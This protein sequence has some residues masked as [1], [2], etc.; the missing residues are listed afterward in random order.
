M[1]LRQLRRKYNENRIIN[2]NNLA[3][4]R[5]TK[6][7]EE[8]GIETLIRLSGNH[9]DLF[10]TDYDEH[11]WGYTLIQPDGKLTIGEM[12]S[13]R[14]FNDKQKYK[15]FDLNVAPTNTVLLS[16]LSND[17]QGWLNIPVGKYTVVLTYGN[18]YVGSHEFTLT[19]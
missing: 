3:I 2:K 8:K 14:F 1:L 6:N 17:Y 11:L 10:P 4:T 16:K 13:Y 7:F 12:H 9:S 5:N 15:E 18:Y 19:D